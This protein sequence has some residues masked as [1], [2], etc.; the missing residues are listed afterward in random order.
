MNE[1]PVPEDTVLVAVYPNEDLISWL[2]DRS[3]FIGLE[4]KGLIPISKGSIDE[5]RQV[6][7]YW[8]HDFRKNSL[9]IQ[10]ISCPSVGSFPVEAVASV[11]VDARN[12]AAIWG[13][14]Q[15][16]VWSPSPG[17]QKA[18]RLLS[19]QVPD[20][21]VYEEHRSNA[22]PFLRWQLHN[23]SKR[24]EFVNNEFYAWN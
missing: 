4:T 17:V 6:W 5:Q 10:R 3:N 1:L 8:H 16:S 12:E 15:V 11:I 18:L 13:F 7:A 23:Q 22:N 21:I 20:K 19:R 9:T 24:I 2:H 14:P